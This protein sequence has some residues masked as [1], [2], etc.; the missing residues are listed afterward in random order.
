MAIQPNKVDPI[1]SKYFAPLEIAEQA[2]TALFGAT[3]TLSIFTLLI[4]KSSYPAIYNICQIVL[5]FAASALFIA[6]LAIRFYLSPRAL[7]MR[8]LDF[9]SQ[10]FQLALTHEQ[11]VG[12]YNN[13]LV[14]PFRKVA[15]QLL[16]NSHFS[17]AI[18]L[19]MVK[20]ERLR[21]GIYGALLIAAFLVRYS[22]FSLITTA[23]QVILSSQIIARW[24][25]MEW[26]RMQ[27][28]HSYSD[29]YNLFLTNPKQQVFQARTLEALTSYESSKALSGVTLS[30]AIFEKLNPSLSQQWEIIK[31]KLNIE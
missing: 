7:K 15:A 23:A 14:D 11:T 10:A 1:R 26:L 20:V 16:E 8:R 29:L 31:Q 30:S 5:I 21:S 22:D 4:E 2:S 13:K 19:E 25:T 28:E 12:Y 17:K 27:F 9:L 24:V 18:T 3:A 6:E